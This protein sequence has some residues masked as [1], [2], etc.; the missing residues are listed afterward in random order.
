MSTE[1]WAG[2]RWRPLLAL[3][4]LAVAL[5]AFVVVGMI[6][7]QSPGGETVA[8]PD[9]HAVFFTSP[10]Y[11]DEPA[12]RAPGLDRHLVA[13]LQAARRS[14]DLAIYDFDLPN[15][16]EALA[17]ARQRGVAVRLVTDTDTV[18]SRDA[19][20]QAALAIVRDARVP[21]VDDQ[22][23]G[24]MHHKFAVVDREW[25]WTG[26]WNFTE[27]DTFRLDNNAAIFHSAELAE[28]FTTEFEKM[29]VLRKFGPTKP[30]DLPH[31][32]VAIGGLTV[33]TCF[34]SEM[35][36]DNL[37]VAE[38]GRAQQSVRFL[39]FSFTHDAI[40]A[41]MIER[42]RAGVHVAGV[43]EKTGSET[44]FS[45]FG[46]LRA[47]GVDVR[48][49]GNPY[50]MHHKVIVIDG[51]VVLFGSFNFSSGAATDNDENLLVIRDGTE[52]AE[53]AHQFLAEYDRVRAQADRGQ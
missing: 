6:R 11:P 19:R 35:Q 40:G 42:Q 28:N 7:W 21:I 51:R 1:R 30:R 25:V 46:R 44:Q 26:S 3:V 41:A 39:A 16:A 9:T 32:R 20:V 4:V 23:S 12:R 34:E 29:F 45:E 37:A 5:A 17:A 10:R 2:A 50:A 36:C 31:P 22:R 14:V 38:I 48:Q 47:A 27:G 18:R 43:V 8:L 53:L 33:D 49:D 13:Y 24:I 52:G 15:V